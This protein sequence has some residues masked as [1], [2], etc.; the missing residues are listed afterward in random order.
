MTVK[1]VDERDDEEQRDNDPRIR[2]RNTPAAA[3]GGNAWFILVGHV[4]TSNENCPQ[5]LPSGSNGAADARE[6]TA[7]DNKVCGQVL[8]A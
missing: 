5:P 8:F 7:Y 1:V 2:E 3:G 4:L 6:A